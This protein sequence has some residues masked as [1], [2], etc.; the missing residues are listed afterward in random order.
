MLRIDK[1][2][3]MI[4]M[5]EGMSTPWGSAQTQT[6]I[7]VGLIW[8]TTAGH[9]GL[10]VS[11][12]KAEATLSDAAIDEGIQYGGYYGY[13]EDAA[14]AIPCYESET[15]LKAVYNDHAS[16]SSKP[17]SYEA[18]K[19]TVERTVHQY[20]SKYLSKKAGE[21]KGLKPSSIEEGDILY[22]GMSDGKNDAYFV[23]GAVYP[24]KRSAWYVAKIKPNGSH[25]GNFF[26]EF[27]NIEAYIE[28]FNGKLFKVGT[29]EWKDLK[30]ILKLR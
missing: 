14:W 27:D 5:I 23:I 15:I 20:F 28:R 9:G 8:V 19:K 3:A 18:F 4:R 21:Y 7:G 6:K 1:D 12:G 25:A 24:K 10:M 17:L 30:T 2:N 13:E 29:R 16:N 26:L 11:R 22:N